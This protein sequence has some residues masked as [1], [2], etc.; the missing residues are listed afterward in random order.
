[1]GSI[2]FAVEGDGVACIL[3]RHRL[4]ACGAEVKDG[5]ATIN[6]SEVARGELVGITGYGDLGLGGI[7]KIA[8]IVGDSMVQTLAQLLKSTGRDRRWVSL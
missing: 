2:D 6:Q 4:P 1:M 7:G 3:S 5:K 8:L